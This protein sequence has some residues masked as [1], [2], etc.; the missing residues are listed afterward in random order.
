[1]GGQGARRARVQRVGALSWISNRY[2]HLSRRDSPGAAR[3]LLRCPFASPSSGINTCLLSPDSLWGSC[4]NI[5]TIQRRSAWSLRKDDTHKSRSGNMSALS[6]F[7]APLLHPLALTCLFYTLHVYIYIYIYIYTYTS[8]YVLYPLALT[9]LFLSVFAA[10]FSILR[11]LPSLSL[12]LCLY[13]MYIYI[14]IYI[15]MYTM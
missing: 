13:Y 11:H 12:S 1:M 9:C 6:I 5:G 4:V 10:P 8:V 15:H 2:T 7:A 14:Y 3:H